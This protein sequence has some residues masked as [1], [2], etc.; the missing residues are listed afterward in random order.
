M[1]QRVRR[2]HVSG[3]GSKQA[4]EKVVCALG[5]QGVDPELPIR[6]LAAPAMLILGP[7]VDEE[8]DPGTWETL[9]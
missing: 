7:V 2:L 5:R 3:H 9:D 1:L 6:G 8:E 4:G